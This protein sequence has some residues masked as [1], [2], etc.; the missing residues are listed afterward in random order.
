MGAIRSPLETFQLAMGPLSVSYGKVEVD[1][2]LI[3]RLLKLGGHKE[4][5]LMVVIPMQYFSTL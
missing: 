2:L 1:K 5:V 3:S 4:E